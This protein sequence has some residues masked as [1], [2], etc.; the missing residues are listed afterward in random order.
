MVI[1]KKYS[2][3]MAH[4]LT[5]AVTECCYETIHGHSYVVE[6]FLRTSQLNA[7]GMVADFGAL[8]DIKKE[9]F[10][11]DHALVMSSDADPQY[12]AMLKKHN[13]K[14]ILFNDNPT[15]EVMA[16]SMLQT[17][18]GLVHG[19]KVFKVRLHETTTGYAEASIDNQEGGCSCPGSTK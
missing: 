2:I 12:L 18:R 11:Y 15:A 9:I 14:L 6:V 4:Q 1:R 8:A 3:E 10:R 5:S 13:K 19:E 17:L 7:A 16:E